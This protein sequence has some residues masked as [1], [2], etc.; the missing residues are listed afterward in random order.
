VET[1][2]S[3]RGRLD[4]P[5]RVASV[6]AIAWLVAVAF[7]ESDAGVPFPRWMVLAGIGVVLLGWW[8]LRLL[9]AAVVGRRNPGILF[10]HAL[11]WA[12]IPGGVVAAVI[13]GNTF[14]LLRAR[15]LL[16][17][18]ALVRAAADLEGIPADDLRVRP[19]RVGLFWVREFQRV[20]SE[21]RFITSECGLVDTCGLIY[22]GAEAPVH[23]GEDSFSHLYGAWWHLYQSW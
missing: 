5:P 19:K 15:V 12:V 17:E 14:A 1:E 2:R 11:A 9:V 8:V 22:S 20:G 18:R 23:R 13:V 16:S 7:A 10:A 21:L 6:L 3:A 4:G